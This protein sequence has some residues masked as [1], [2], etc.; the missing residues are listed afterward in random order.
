MKPIT[1]KKKKK[2]N[3]QTK[4]H[5]MHQVFY[6]IFDFIYNLQ[7]KTNLELGIDQIFSYPYSFIHFNALKHYSKIFLTYHRKQNLEGSKVCIQ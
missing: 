3:H 4:K 6:L 7:V 2:K 1:K 5:L